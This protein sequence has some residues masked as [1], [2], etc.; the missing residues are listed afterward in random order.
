[1][2]NAVMELNDIPRARAPG[3]MVHEH[4]GC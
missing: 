3:D 2:D 1:V 4:S